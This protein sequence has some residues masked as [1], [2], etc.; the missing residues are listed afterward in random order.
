MVSTACVDCGDPNAQTCLHAAPRLEAVGELLVE[1][2]AVAGVADG[3]EHGAADRD[4]VGLVEVAAAPG[5]AEV[6]GDHDLR[7]GDGAPRSAIARAQR[8]AVLEDAVRQSEEVDHVDADD[9]GRLDLLGLADRR[10]TRP[11]AMPSMPA[12]PLVTMQ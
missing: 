2:P 9:R 6:A 12:S 8:D 5:V 11:G 1:D 7:A 4:V 10:G 3:V